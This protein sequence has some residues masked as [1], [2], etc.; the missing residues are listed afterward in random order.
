MW[1]TYQIHST[2]NQMVLHTRTILSSSAT[3][4]NNTMLLDIV[5]YPTSSS[6]SLS[7]F[8]WAGIGNAKGK[9]SRREHTLPRNISR[10][11]L[12]TT[13]PNSRRLP[14]P[15]IR[16]LGLRN[17]RFQANTLH[18]RPVHERRRPRSPRTLRNPAP[19]AHLVVCCLADGR[20]VELTTEEGGGACCCCFCRCC[21]QGGGRAE[22]GLELELGGR[23]CRGFG[24]YGGALDDCPQCAEGKGGE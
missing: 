19:P 2:T 18:L 7:Q 1:R 14:L 10:N 23:C 20:G 5:T 8:T 17:P 6:Q 9:K 16:L 3:N 4:K 12:P 24:E 11:N 13:Q 21:C 22:D 15:R